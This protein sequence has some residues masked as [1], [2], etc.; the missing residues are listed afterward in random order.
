MKRGWQQGGRW[1]R[2]SDIKYMTFEHLASAIEWCEKNGKP[3]PTP[4]LGEKEAR[5]IWASGIKSWVERQ[6]INDTATIA[7][8]VLDGHWAC[9]CDDWRDKRQCSHVVGRM[10]DARPKMMT[11]SIDVTV[12]MRKD[13]DDW[14]KS[15]DSNY[16]WGS[17]SETELR[18]KN[19]IT[20][21]PKKK[22]LVIEVEQ[23]GG[24]RKI[25]L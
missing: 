13:F 21:E 10:R 24:K 8:Y 17:F 20:R 14:S 2:R 6:K 19:E 12:I 4:L 11:H 1:W 5:E 16:N 3:V 18:D 9:T 23:I 7:R 15:W 25:K 22:K